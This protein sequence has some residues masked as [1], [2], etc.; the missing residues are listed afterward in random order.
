MGEGDFYEQDLLWKKFFTIIPVRSSISKK[1]IF[2]RKAYTRKTSVA[3]KRV[4][5]TE[6]EYIIEK[7]T[8][9]V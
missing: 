5:L 8:G 1:F 6:D 7:L 2:F 3:A 4:W 9:N